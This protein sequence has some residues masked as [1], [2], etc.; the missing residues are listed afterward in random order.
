KQAWPLPT[1][2]CVGRRL[3]LLPLPPHRSRHQQPEPPETQRYRLSIPIP[4][5]LA[6]RPLRGALPEVAR[7]SPESASIPVHRSAENQGVDRPIVQKQSTSPQQPG[8]PTR[9]AV[10]YHYLQSR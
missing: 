10:F 4:P 7:W 3:T 2:P 8:I 9:S 1:K 6:V 5:R